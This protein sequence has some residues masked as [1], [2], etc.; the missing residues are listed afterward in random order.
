MQKTLCFILKID[1]A[2]LGRTLFG[3]EESLSGGRERE[4]GSG[5][6]ERRSGAEVGSGDRERRSGAEV[7][8]GGREQEVGSGE[9]VAGDSGCLNRN[10]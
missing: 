2:I 8:S 4:V 9:E 3:R 7:G 6:R 10:A 1:P 5:G